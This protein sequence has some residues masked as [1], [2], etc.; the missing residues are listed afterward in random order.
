MTRSIEDMLGPDPD[1]AEIEQTAEIVERINKTYAYVYGKGVIREERDGSIS[2]ESVREFEH[3]F[4]NDGVWSRSKAGGDVFTPS[5]RIWMQSPNRRQFTRI[6]LDPRGDAR[7]AYNLWQGY[8]YE[9]GGKGSCERFLDH[10]YDNVCSGNADDF[11]WLVGW[12]A[13]AIQ[14]PWEKPGTA[15]VLKGKPGVGKSSVGEHFGALMPRHHVTVYTPRGLTGQFNAHMA[16]ALL[17]QIEEGFWAG[18]KAAEGALKHLITG[19]T[20]QLEKKGVDAIELPSFH[21]YLMTSNERWTV[22]A[23]HDERR[24]AI[25]NVSDARAQDGAYFG[26]ISRDMCEGGYRALMRHLLDFDLSSVDVRTIPHTEALAAE[27][28]AGLRGIQAWWHEVLA[29][30]D[31]PCDAWGRFN[32]PKE[33]REQPISLRVDDMRGAFELWMRSRRHH[34]D[35]LTAEMFGREF[36]DICPRAQRVQRREKHTRARFYDLPRLSDCRRDFEKWLD[37]TVEWS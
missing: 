30:G 20:I 29:S 12:M 9:P 10:L 18:D 14:K 23:R 34:G 3:W 11:A 26:A 35:V 8:A 17:V 22:P 27:K 2:I 31:V 1:S 37:S 19:P 28:I 4:A 5:S 33:W 16:T 32:E 6:V 36:R 21:R 15:V 25:F 24:Y 7:D 13:H